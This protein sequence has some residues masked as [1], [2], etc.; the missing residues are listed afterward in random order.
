M[1]EHAVQA[2]A[3]AKPKTLYAVAT[4]AAGAGVSTAGGADDG[5][6][7]RTF[8]TTAASSGRRSAIGWRSTIGW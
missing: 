5:S 6:F 7:M 4:R 8:V 2:D 1:I 3:V